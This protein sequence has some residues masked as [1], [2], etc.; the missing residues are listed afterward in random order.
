[1][2]R[3]VRFECGDVAKH[4]AIGV[5]RHGEAAAQRSQ[6]RKSVQPVGGP[7]HPVAP[8]V[9]HTRGRRDEADVLPL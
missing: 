3:L 9:H 4:P 8:P 5:E 1:M 6:R 7:E 2:E